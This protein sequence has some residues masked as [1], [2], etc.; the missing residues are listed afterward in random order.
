GGLHYIASAFIP[1]KP[2]ET[3]IAT[4]ASGMYPS[5]AATNAPDAPQQAEP[6][7]LPNEHDG[8]VGTMPLRQ[9]VDVVRKLAEALPYAH[10]QGIVHR[11]VK[12]GNV[13]L[14]EDGEPLLM[15]FGLAAR[16]DETER[17]TVAGQFMGTP[18]YAAPEQWRGN[19][20]ALSDQYSLGC[21]LY[22][23]LTGRRAFEGSTGEHYL[24]L[25]PT[26]APPPPRPLPPELRRDWET[27]CLKCLEKEP[28]RRYA[29]CQALADDLRR[30]LEGEPVSARRPSALERLTRWAR[31]NPAV[32]ALAA[33][34]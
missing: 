15:D 19:A 13:M 2:L 5:A 16:H 21:V 22:E 10:R 20:G 30:W 6:Q 7:S 11:D 9:A 18:E 24:L 14:R 4:A 25:P 28:H 17:L 26:Q 27:V 34:V 32:A 3:A 33:A 8:P 31:K 23:M 12:P 1:G 29:D